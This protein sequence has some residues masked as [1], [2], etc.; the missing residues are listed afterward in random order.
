MKHGL[1]KAEFVNQ[2]IKKFIESTSMDFAEYCGALGG[3]KQNDK[4]N[5]GGRVYNQELF[6]DFVDQNSDYDRYG[7]MKLSN[8]KF[9]KWLVS[10]SKFQFDCMP[11]EG[12]DAPGKWVRFRNKHELESNGNFE[13]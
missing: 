11:D 13:F 1:I 8:T 9:N 6:L 7:K 12:R 2:S 3:P 5:I 10:Y 4:L